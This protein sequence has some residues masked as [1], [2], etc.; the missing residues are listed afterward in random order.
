MRRLLDQPDQRGRIARHADDA[1]LVALDAQ[2]GDVGVVGQ[3]L[4][5]HLEH[6]HA[7]R[8]LVLAAL[9]HAQRGRGLRAAVAAG[10]ERHAA[11]RDAARQLV[12]LAGEVEAD[13]RGG[14]ER[15][16]GEQPGCR[17]ARRRSAPRTRA[18][19]IAPRALVLEHPDRRGVR[20]QA[21]RDRDRFGAGCDQR[22]DQRLHQR[23][24]GRRDR[25]HHAVGA[26]LRGRAPAERGFARA[27]GRQPVDL[28]AHDA[29]EEFGRALRQ[30]ERAEQEARRA[31][32][33]ARRGCR[34]AAVSIAVGVRRDQLPVGDLRRARDGA[35]RPAAWITNAPSSSSITC[36]L[37][38]RAQR[39]QHADDRG[40]D[41][42]DPARQ[43]GRDVG[44]RRSSHR[45]P[46][47]FGRRVVDVV[48][49]GQNAVRRRCRCR[50]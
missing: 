9:E 14:A 10:A 7:R 42:I 40:G 24:R 47:A 8:G 48:A 12:L 4:R 37:R 3:D 33:P 44:E 32:A 2:L 16:A 50:V 39:R 19:S 6:D 35:L 28:R 36:T 38:A 23:A 1:Q 31:A 25:H 17:S 49:P 29:V 43:I 26:G 20:P 21:A 41:R 45:G 18:A 15:H 27:P 22:I 11:L 5:Q 46:A 34:A 13:D 30:F